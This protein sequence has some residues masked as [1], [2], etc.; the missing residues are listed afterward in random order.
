MS[1]FHRIPKHLPVHM[2]NIGFPC[3]CMA[4]FNDLL[5]LF[6][7]TFHCALLLPISI[8]SSVALDDPLLVAAYSHQFYH[9]YA[10]PHTTRNGM[11]LFGQ[12]LRR[13]LGLNSDESSHYVAG[14]E[15]DWRPPIE[16]WKQSKARYRAAATASSS[17]AYTTASASGSGLSSNNNLFP[18]SSPPSPP[19]SSPP[20][21]PARPR[22]CFV[23]SFLYGGH[24][25]VRI[26][27]EVAR[28]LP[29]KG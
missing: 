3:R 13:S 12:V 18:P 22:L 16:E 19:P 15:L 9:A 6:S 17:S 10:P 14:F 20:L 23:S 24:Q 27:D 5:F 26:F 21:S 28:R 11:E 2:Y 4:F 8:R 25:L 1:K 29:A 7:S